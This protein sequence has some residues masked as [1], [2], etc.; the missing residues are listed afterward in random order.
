MSAALDVDAILCFGEQNGGCGTEAGKGLGDNSRKL[1]IENRE[2]R[3]YLPLLI[4]IKP[5]TLLS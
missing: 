4:K 5:P 1:K 2:S 3:F